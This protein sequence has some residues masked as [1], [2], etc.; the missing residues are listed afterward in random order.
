MKVAHVDYGCENADTRGNNLTKRVISQESI[1]ICKHYLALKNY[2]V[3][4]V[5]INHNH[6]Y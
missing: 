4:V 6:L 5:P 1:Y 3:N 2:Q